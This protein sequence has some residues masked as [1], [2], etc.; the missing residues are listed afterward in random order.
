MISQKAKYALRALVAL[1]R[2]GAAG[3]ALI[4]ADIAERQNIP[5]KFLE[6]ILLDLKRHG[7]LESRRGKN[8]GY[9]LLRPADKITF[10]EILRIVDGPIAPLPCLSKIAYR[11]CGDCASEASCEVRRI[12]AKV[13]EATRAVLDTATIADAIADDAALVQTAT[14]SGRKSARAKRLT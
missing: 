14:S 11:P 1:A 7:V 13:T 9:G 2:A 3:E 4:I 12:F 10:G 8:G 5:R 6:Q